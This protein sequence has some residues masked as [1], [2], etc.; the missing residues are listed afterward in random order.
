MMNATTKVPRAKVGTRKEGY[1]L[2]TNKVS[3]KK[4]LPEANK[5]GLREMTID[6]AG[7]KAFLERYETD[8]EFRKELD[9]LELECGVSVCSDPEVLKAIEAG[10]FPKEEE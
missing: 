5:A 3:R 9:K 10:H 2:S 6:P 1:K 8:E 4:V 7:M